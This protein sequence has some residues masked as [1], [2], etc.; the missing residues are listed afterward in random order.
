M[1]HRSSPRRGPSA[2]SVSAR[3]SRLVIWPSCSNASSAR[4]GA[5]GRMRASRD[6][7]TLTAR[8]LSGLTFSMPKASARAL[9][10]FS[11]PPPSA[12]STV[13]REAPKPA[14]PECRN[15]GGCGPSESAPRAAC[16]MQQRPDQVERATVQRYRLDSARPSEAGGPARRRTVRAKTA[17]FVRGT[18]LASVTPTPWKNGSHEAAHRPCGRKRRIYA[19]PHEGRRPAMLLALD[20]RLRRGQVGACAEVEFGLCDGALGLVAETAKPSSPMR[21]R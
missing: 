17:H 3:I 20:D 11:S 4:P 18:F 12:A 9:R 10:I 7:S 16:G 2:E 1:S 6:D 21:R 13:R 15:G 14:G 8:T 5:S 19:F